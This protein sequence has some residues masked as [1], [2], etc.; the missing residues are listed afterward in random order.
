M[1]VFH[2]TEDNV[3]SKKIINMAS[4]GR[5]ISLFVSLRKLEI[6]LKTIMWIIIYF[7]STRTSDVCPGIYIS[8]LELQ[9]K[10]SPYDPQL[11]CKTQHI[12]QT[13]VLS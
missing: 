5:E 2:M 11:M 7:Q 6:L 1:Y 3:T 8:P 4:K 9:Q 10:L 13:K 12:V